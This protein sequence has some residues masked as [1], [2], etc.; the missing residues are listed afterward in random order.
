MDEGNR[1]KGWFGDHY[2][3]FHLLSGDALHK[4]LK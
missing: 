3:I 2:V 1:E 4:E